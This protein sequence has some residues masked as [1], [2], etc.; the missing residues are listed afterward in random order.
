MISFSSSSSAALKPPTVFFFFHNYCLEGDLL[1]DGGGAR[2]YI[3]GA[4]KFFF[5]VLKIVFTLKFDNSHK[6]QG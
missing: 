6:N 4:T 3:L 2:L 5:S 1:T